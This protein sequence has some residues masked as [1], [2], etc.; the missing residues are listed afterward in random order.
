MEM[1]NTLTEKGDFC[2][3]YLKYDFGAK[4]FVLRRGQCDKHVLL[5]VFAP[6]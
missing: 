1:R 4:S 2:C 5:F 6:N 3:F